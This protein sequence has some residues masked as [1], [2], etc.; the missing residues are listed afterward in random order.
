MKKSNGNFTSMS[1]VNNSRKRSNVCSG[2][3][4]T[5]KQ[6]AQVAV[7]PY[8]KWG[9]QILDEGQ[10]SEKMIPSV[11]LSTHGPRP[12]GTSPWPYKCHLPNIAKGAKPD[13]VG[14]LRGGT[15]L[16]VLVFGVTWKPFPGPG[17]TSQ[18]TMVDGFT[19]GTPA[20]CMAPLSVMIASATII[21]LGPQPKSPLLVQNHLGAA[22]F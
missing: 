4:W 17:V 11:A 5:A 18:T 7:H 1:R 22:P 6:F 21:P 19:V 13:Q 16:V 10:H 12:H 2:P 3:L 14:G 15:A 20:T 8:W 9:S